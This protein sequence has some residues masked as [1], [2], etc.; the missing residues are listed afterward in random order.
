MQYELRSQA[1]LPCT[2]RPISSRL[3]PA[4]ASAPRGTVTVRMT[5][6]Q[7]QAS[8]RKEAAALA[9]SHGDASAPRPRVGTMAKRVVITRAS[10]KRP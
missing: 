1:W 9:A 8:T 10:T 2:R 7:Q 3:A 6:M 5:T 4:D